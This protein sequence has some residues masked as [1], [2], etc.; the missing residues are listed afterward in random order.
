M[1]GSSGSAESFLAFV[2]HFDEF[3]AGLAWCYSSPSY[4][5]FTQ[6][7]IQVLSE[8]MEAVY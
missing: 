5:S 7:R 2:H 8:A 6:K 1:P 3:A 4:L